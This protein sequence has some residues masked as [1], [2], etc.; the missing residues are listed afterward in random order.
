MTFSDDQIRAFVSD[1][2]NHPVE[3]TPFGRYRLIEL[4]GRGGM[5]EVWRAYDSDTDRIVAIKVLPAHFSDNE[6]FKQRFRREAHAAA[7]LIS[8]GQ[9]FAVEQYA[10]RVTVQP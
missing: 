4:L 1:P 10:D 9:R 7:L 6:D 3:G 8:R 2:S 5:G